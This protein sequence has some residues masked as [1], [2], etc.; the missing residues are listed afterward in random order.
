LG[1]I[2]LDNSYGNYLENY[3]YNKRKIET[4]K[5]SDF[6]EEVKHEIHD[7][8]TEELIDNIFREITETYHELNPDMNIKDYF[9]IVKKIL[10]DHSSS[11]LHLLIKLLF[12]IESSHII[13]TSI[14]ECL[15]TKVIGERGG[16]KFKKTKTTKNK[17]QKN[18]SRRKKYKKR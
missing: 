12:H 18:K 7:T 14:S 8:L 16:K 15:L 1:Y 11:Q 5:V 9:N 2:C 3:E 6:I 13:T 4:T 17:K 10:R